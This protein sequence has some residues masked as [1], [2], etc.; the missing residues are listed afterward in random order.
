M[1]RRAL[2]TKAAGHTGTLDPFATGLLIVLTGRGTRLARFVEGQPKIYLA[3]AR[4]GI[5]TET[6]DATGEMIGKPVALPPLTGDVIRE[7]L[8]GFTGTSL[9]RPPVYS[10]KRVDGQRSHRLARRGHPV[11][12]ADVEITVY[13]IELVAWDGESVVFRAEVSAGTYL[14]AIAR[15]LGER[16]GTGAHLTALRREAIGGLDVSRAVAPH[17]V[18]PATVLPLREVLR[19]LPSM[20]LD[21]AALHDVAH[22]R[23]VRGAPA[24]SGPIA[25]LHDHEVVA[26]G[27]S[28]DG[29]LRPTVVLAA[30]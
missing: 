19:H 20:E 11:E 25:A 3:T 23:A 17:D 18:T 21:H 6:D 5:R 26:V 22:G 12:L 10:A 1:V 15:D 14:R 13:R 7:A 28:E 30:P 16:L 24:S 27:R 2:G 8:Q 9:Q 4:L 29:W